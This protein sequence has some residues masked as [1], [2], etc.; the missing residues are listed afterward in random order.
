MEKF[1]GLKQNGNV[2]ISS[3][4]NYPEHIDKRIQ[5]SDEVREQAMK[6]HTGDAM[7]S[8][9][10]EGR[11]KRRNV[12]GRRKRPLIRKYP[13]GATLPEQSGNLIRSEVGEVKHLS[14][15]IE[16]KSPRWPK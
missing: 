16:K 7:A 4:L 12:A 11:S 13:N 8:D 14:S 10:E 5:G 1:S 9:S 2:Y 6:E 3:G 15:R